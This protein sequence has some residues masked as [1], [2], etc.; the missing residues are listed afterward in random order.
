MKYDF[1]V[2]PPQMTRRPF[3]HVAFA[4]LPTRKF[5]GLAD[6]GA[7]KTRVSKDWADLLGLDLTQAKPQI[8]K[9]A[10]N[11]YFSHVMPVELRVEKYTWTCDVGFTE[12][13]D[14]HA[15][16]GLRGF[17]DQFVVRFDARADLTTLTPLR[18]RPEGT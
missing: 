16:L 8:F 10:G 17:F 14:H 5:W 9:I 11:Q 15:V 13:W 18:R 4:D 6:S 1:Q 12:D 3:V 7:G 2:I